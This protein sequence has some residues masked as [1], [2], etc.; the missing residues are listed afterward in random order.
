[1]DGAWHL[2]RP[3]ERWRGGPEWQVRAVLATEAWTAV[4]YRLPVLEL[5]PTGEERE[6]LDHLGPDPLA[7]DWDAAEALRRLTA[8]PERSIGEA[9][10]DQRVIAGIGN[11]WRCEICFL[12]GLEPD[13]PVRAVGDPAAL[14]ALVKRMFEANRQPAARSPPATR[15]AAVRTTSTAAAASRAAAAA[16]RSAGR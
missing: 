8:D 2:Y 1:M 13:A 7:D 16:R 15:A 5:F 9:L 4:G 3:A 14:V 10:L 12:R 6:R 11:V